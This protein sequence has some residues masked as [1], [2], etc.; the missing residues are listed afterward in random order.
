[1]DGSVLPGHLQGR[2]SQ[3]W[4]WAAL[5][6]FLTLESWSEPSP[7]AWPVLGTWEAFPS[8]WSIPSQDQAVAGEPWQHQSGCRQSESGFDPWAQEFPLW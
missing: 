4:H 6:R 1:M 8:S 2:E 7:P 3:H 5:E